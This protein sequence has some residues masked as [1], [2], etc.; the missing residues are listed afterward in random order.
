MILVVT[1]DENETSKKRS[2]KA[3]L[4]HDAH[5][6]LRVCRSVWSGQDGSSAMTLSTV[7]QYGTVC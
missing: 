6:L 3:L 1:N 7:G 2:E 5:L 4:L